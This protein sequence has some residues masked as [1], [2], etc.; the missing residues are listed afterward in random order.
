MSNPD[1]SLMDTQYAKDQ[2]DPLG[3]RTPVGSMTDS[4]RRAYEERLVESRRDRDGFAW[5]FVFTIL[6]S[7][8]L[9]LVAFFWLQVVP[10]IAR[11]YRAVLMAVL[12]DAWFSAPGDDDPQPVIVASVV[13]VAVVLILVGLFLLR[14]RIGYIWARGTRGRFVLWLAQYPLSAVIVF[15]MVLTPGL[16]VTAAG[17]TRSSL[18]GGSAGPLPSWPIVLTVITV[19]WWSIGTTRRAVRRAMR[20][21]YREWQ[22]TGDGQWHPPGSWAAPT[23]GTDLST[24]C[25][26]PPPPPM[27]PQSWPP[28]SS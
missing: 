20:H 21:R 3:L 6:P 1:D 14:G 17:V 23:N 16:I 7:F 27:P 5:R 8:M 25:S 2:R 11:P 24:P 12:P 9:L 26:P 13:G 4:Q 22:L 10:S 28:Q 15:V 19:L 18:F